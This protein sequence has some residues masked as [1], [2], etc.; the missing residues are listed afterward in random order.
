MY[1]IEIKKGVPFSFLQ[2]FKLRHSLFLKHITR[3][4]NRSKTCKM[5]NKK[6]IREGSFIYFFFKKRENLS[7]F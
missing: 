4:A 3:L 5:L 1:L 7:D 2:N 6:I